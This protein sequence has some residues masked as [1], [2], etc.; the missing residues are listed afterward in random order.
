MD[1]Y[2][3]VGDELSVFGQ[4]QCW[5]WYVRS[6]IDHAL[7]GHVLEVGAGIGSST[8][9]LRSERQ[10][11]WTC[12]EPDAEMADAIARQVAFDRLPVRVVR[13]TTAHLLPVE[14][15]DAIVYLDV[16]EHIEDDRAELARAAAHLA[17]GGRLIVLSP[18]HQWLFTPFDERIGHWRRYSRRLLRDVVPAGLEVERLVY[19]DAAGLLLSL[20]N[21]L[22]L[23]SASPSVRQVRTWDRWFVP[24][25]RVIDPILG[26]HVGKSL[27]AIWR[28]EDR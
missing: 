16:L 24:V 25:S 10:T 9:A 27:L 21:R 5:K 18:A 12:L 6:Q 13:G 26:H 28:R 19:L 3:Y 17:P 2:R 11:S 22:V 14:R 15:Y 4:A 8:V 7:V 23:R 1:A 20:A